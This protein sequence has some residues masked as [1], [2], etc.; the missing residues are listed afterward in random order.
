LEY[1]IEKTVHKILN[2]PEL[3]DFLG[4]RLLEGR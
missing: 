1:D 2:T 3:D 4:H